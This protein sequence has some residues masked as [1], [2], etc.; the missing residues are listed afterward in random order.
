[1]LVGTAAAGAPDFVGRAPQGDGRLEDAAGAQ[2]RAAGRTAMTTLRIGA[3]SAWWGDRLEPARLNAEQG[4][5][6]YLCLETMAE[7]T[8]STAQL[9]RR[10]DPSLPGY[11]L[12]FDERLQHILPGCL[13][14]GTKI[15]SNEGWIIP[16]RRAAGGRTRAGGRRPQPQ[17]RGGLAQRSRT[18]CWN[19]ATP[20]WRTEV[21]SPRSR[22]TV[23]AEAYLGAEPIVEALRQG[24]N[25]VM[26]TRVADPSLFV[27]PMIHE[28]RWDP[29]DHARLGQGT[30]IG[31]IWNAARSSPA[32]ISAIPD[33]RTC[34]SLGSWRSHRR[35]RAGRQRGDHQGRGTGGAVNLMTVKEQIFYEV[36]D[37]ARY[38][39][40]DVVWTSLPSSSPKPDPRGCASAGSAASRGRRL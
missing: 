6:D 19:S 9:R 24:A 17:G 34:R 11:D 32:A 16:R 23:S 3:G 31:H 39:T 13:R 8:V 36:H 4:N 10:R 14:R 1:M 37:P 5:L 27:A 7:A 28:F 26:T 15:V 2:A 21:R 40:P 29:L 38:V 12:N 25:I 22:T 20:S 33:S 18:E 30:G 35:G